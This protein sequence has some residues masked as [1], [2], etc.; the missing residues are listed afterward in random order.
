MSVWQSVGSIP[1]RR[2][3]FGKGKNVSLER[4]KERSTRRETQEIVII[5]STFVHE[6]DVYYNAV[7]NKILS[8]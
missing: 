4:E 1:L 3:V 8:R 6:V 2:A 5:L 7:I